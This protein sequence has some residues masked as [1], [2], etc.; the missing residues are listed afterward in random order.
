MNLASVQLVYFSPTHT[1]ERVLEA[2]ARGMHI[3]ATRRFD[4]TPPTAEQGSFEVPGEAVAFHRRR[5]ADCGGPGAASRRRSPS[6]SMATVHTRTR[7]W[8]CAIW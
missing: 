5:H 1:T 6:S 3:L 2:I 8:S 4:L 7:C